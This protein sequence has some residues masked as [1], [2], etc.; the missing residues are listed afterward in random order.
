MQL[1]SAVPKTIKVRTDK[2]TGECYLRLNDFKDL[3]DISTVK[4]YTLEPID[5]GGAQCLIVTFYDADGEIIQAQHEKSGA[6]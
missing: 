5:D 4:S 2:K 6:V 1:V 3:L